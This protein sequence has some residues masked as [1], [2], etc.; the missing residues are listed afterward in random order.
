M[1]SARTAAS[2]L[3]PTQQ[4]SATLATSID[5]ESAVITTHCALDIVPGAVDN[6]RQYCRIHRPAALRLAPA[7]GRHGMNAEHFFATVGLCD[8]LRLIG[9]AAGE[10]V[11]DASHV[12]ALVFC[13]GLR[14]AL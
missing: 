3:R 9:P 12:A 4:P 13:S 11:I 8:A 5:A 1:I 14:C 7:A 10:G 6:R 2:V